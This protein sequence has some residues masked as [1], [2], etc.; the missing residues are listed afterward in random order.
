LP[1]YF[2]ASNEGLQLTNTCYIKP[3]QFQA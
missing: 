3:K 1:K 2:T